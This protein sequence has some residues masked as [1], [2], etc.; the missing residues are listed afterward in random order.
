MWMW[1]LYGTSL[2]SKVRSSPYCCDVLLDQ[3]LNL[4]LNKLHH[5]V[6]GRFKPTWPTSVSDLLYFEKFLILGLSLCTQKLDHEDPDKLS[7]WELT[8]FFT[9]SN[10]LFWAFIVLSKTTSLRLLMLRTILGVQGDFLPLTH[11]YICWF[12]P[13]LSTNTLTAFSSDYGS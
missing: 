13:P 3:R 2:Y 4:F 9:L 12:F 1:S 10:F 7:C 6:Q 8:F 5:L 11:W